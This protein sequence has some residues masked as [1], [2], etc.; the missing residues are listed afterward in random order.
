MLFDIIRS[1]LSLQLTTDLE[2]HS[3]RDRI[4]HIVSCSAKTGDGLQEAMEWV[5]GQI[6]SDDG[7][8]GISCINYYGYMIVLFCR[9]P[10][11]KLDTS[12]RAEKWL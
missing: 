8:C 4:W 10:R 5:V 12:R 9:R 2:L 3:I 1:N 11:D 6:N 7:V